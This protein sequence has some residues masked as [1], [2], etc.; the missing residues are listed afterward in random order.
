[1]LQPSVQGEAAGSFALRGSHGLSVLSPG[2]VLRQSD[3]QQLKNVM[4]RL[5]I[6]AIA[7]LSPHY[8]L[9]GWAVESSRRNSDTAMTRAETCSDELI[10]C[11]RTLLPILQTGVV[12][13]NPL[14]NASSAYPPP[15]NARSSSVTHF[16]NCRICI[17]LL[18]KYKIL[19][20][21][22]P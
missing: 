22:C 16:P 13:S 9:D 5:E 4:S 19:L 12:T 21:Y 6:S 8:P 3:E 18:G 14:M 15:L 10:V 20:T 17:V 2:G 11:P 1:V 7:Q